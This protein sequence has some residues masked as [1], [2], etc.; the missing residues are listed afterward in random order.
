[1]NGDRGLEGVGVQNAFSC[2]LLGWFVCLVN[3]NNASVRS[4]LACELLHENAVVWYQ[5]VCIDCCL[6]TC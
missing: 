6:D 4:N 5:L 2:N 1:M 3:A